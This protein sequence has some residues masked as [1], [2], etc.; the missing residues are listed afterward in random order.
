MWPFSRKPSNP[1]PSSI[2][3]KDFRNW[4][5]DW[6]IGDIAE[7]VSDRW[8]KPMKPWEKLPLGSRWLVTGFDE[9]LAE[10]N[11]LR[12]F[13]EIKGAPLKAYSTTAFRKV[14]PVTKSAMIERILEAPGGPDKVR[15]LQN[16]K[17]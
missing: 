1:L 2:P 10:D 11:T 3:P 13:L 17:L 16:E 14:K 6:K 7:V 9:G 12:Y 5:E 15:E 4:N 8:F